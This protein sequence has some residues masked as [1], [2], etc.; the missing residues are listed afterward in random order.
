MTAGGRR[1]SSSSSGSIAAPLLASLPM[2]L[3][4]I[5]F[6][7][8]G[9]LLLWMG[10]DIGP[11]AMPLWAL[12]LV[13]G[14]VAS[15][16]TVISWFFVEEARSDRI[17]GNAPVAAVAPPVRSP[18]LGRP[19]PSV[20]PAARPSVGGAAAARPSVSAAPAAVEPWDEGPIAPPAR[21]EP[22]ARPVP[23][24]VPPYGETGRVLEEL[25]GIEREVAPR[26]KVD[27]PVFR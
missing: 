18:D 26:R 27:A 20:A 10:V 23:P 6:F 9:Y 21:S 17:P 2:L 5:A 14:F 15:I 7:A 22:P 12:F 11:G 24:L 13:L 25:E 1:K 4:A 19:R 8:A 16:G 3:L